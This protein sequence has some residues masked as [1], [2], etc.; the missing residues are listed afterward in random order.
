MDP[1]YLAS[2]A[3]ISEIPGTLMED[4][5]FTTVLY[6]VLGEMIFYRFLVKPK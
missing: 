5:D 3:F 6:G 1:T 4:I 2:Q